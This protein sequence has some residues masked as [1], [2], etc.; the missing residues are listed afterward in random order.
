MSDD[1]DPRAQLR[2]LYLALVRLE[3]RRIRERRMWPV[4]VP[5]LPPKLNRYVRV[6][7]ASYLR[8]DAGSLDK[9][10]GLQTAGRKRDEHAHKAVVSI[11]LPMLEKGATRA[12]IL[13]ELSA[14]GFEKVDEKQLRVIL[15]R[16]RARMEAEAEAQAW[17]DATDIAAKVVDRLG[18]NDPD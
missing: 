5:E 12:A 2:A 11:A 1:D 4:V 7:L 14:A 9:A 18:R 17:L 16:E 10:F 6:A 3:R 8:G 15:R 13:D